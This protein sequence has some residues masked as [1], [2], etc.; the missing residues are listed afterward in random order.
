MASKYR[1][2]P[3]ASERRCATTWDRIL[4]DEIRNDERWDGYARRRDADDAR[5]WEQ[6]DSRLFGRRF[7][8]G[9]RRRSIVPERSGNGSIHNSSRLL[10]RSACHRERE[11]CRAGPPFRQA[12][13]Q[14]AASRAWCARAFGLEAL[15]RVADARSDSTCGDL[16][17]RSRP[18]GRG[19]FVPHL[20]MA[21]R[22]LHHAPLGLLLMFTGK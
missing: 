10:A 15:R 5:L 18:H 9:G 8:Y 19:R 12:L 6:V 1:C 11:G 7:A 20:A 22:L 14:G 13:G 16:S 2:H 3:D 21:K 17:A 4:Y